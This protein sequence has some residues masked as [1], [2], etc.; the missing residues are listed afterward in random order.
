MTKRDAGFINEGIES[1]QKRGSRIVGEGARMLPAAPMGRR[2]F[3]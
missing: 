3:V 1:V 2:M